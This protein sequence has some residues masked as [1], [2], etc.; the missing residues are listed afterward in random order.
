MLICMLTLLISLLAVRS[1][2]GLVTAGFIIVTAL[3]INRDMIRLYKRYIP[4]G[5]ALT[6][7]VLILVIPYQSLVFGEG[8][9]WFSK[10]YIYDASYIARVEAFQKALLPPS[11]RLL[12]F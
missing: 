7:L 9:I 6:G 8:K 11:R 5:L 1:R 10:D 12:N 3:W 4:I 2:G